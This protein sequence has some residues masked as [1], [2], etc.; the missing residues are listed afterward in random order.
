[1]RIITAVV[2]TAV[3]EFGITEK[4]RDRAGGY[5]YKIEPLFKR[6]PK[7]IVLKFTAFKVGLKVVLVPRCQ[8]I[9]SSAL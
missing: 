7:K 5:G 2:V 8:R 3:A 6:E 1:V 9:S 4:K